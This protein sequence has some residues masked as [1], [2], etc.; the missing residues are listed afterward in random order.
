MIDTEYFF[1]SFS[2][3]IFKVY[4]LLQHLI[5]S[6]MYLMC[7]NAKSCIASFIIYFHWN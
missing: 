7:I 2:V 3:L 4:R 6:R 1:L 5:K